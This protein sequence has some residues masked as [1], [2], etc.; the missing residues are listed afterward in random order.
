LQA[1]VGTSTPRTSAEPH[2]RCGT[3]WK[4]VRKSNTGVRLQP[5][6][7]MGVW[8]QSPRSQPLKKTCNF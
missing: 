1:E 2:F 7:V 5:P 4:K 3:G 8:E 6:E